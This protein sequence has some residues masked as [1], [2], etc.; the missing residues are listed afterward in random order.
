MYVSCWS[1]VCPVSVQ[2]VRRQWQSWR[3]SSCSPSS[4]ACTTSPRWEEDQ[5]HD[6]STHRIYID[7]LYCMYLNRIA[8]RTTVLWERQV[9]NDIYLFSNVLHGTLYLPYLLQ[10]RAFLSQRRRVKPG[11][12]SCSICSSHRWL[13]CLAQERKIIRDGLRIK[14]PVSHS[15]SFLIDQLATLSDHTGGIMT[16][17]RD[18]TPRAFCVCVLGEDEGIKPGISK[19]SQGS[20]TLQPIVFQLMSWD[21]DKWSTRHV[22]L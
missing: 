13:S 16:W 19:C 5:A 21:A 20:F 10:Q 11:L 17:E 15:D 3:R 7:V 1:Y 9:S 2:P 6:C 18:S 4:S 14:S 22:L 12:C 8:R